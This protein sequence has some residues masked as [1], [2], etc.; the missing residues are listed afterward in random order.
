[1]VSVLNINLMVDYL[2]IYFPPEQRQQ[3]LLMKGN[4][5][6]GVLFH[7]IIRVKFYYQ[8]VEGWGIKS[9]IFILPV[10]AILVSIKRLFIVFCIVHRRKSYQ[11]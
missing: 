3:C 10:N 8:A 5:C 2:R 7:Y 6:D 4:I 9:V 11:L 1:M